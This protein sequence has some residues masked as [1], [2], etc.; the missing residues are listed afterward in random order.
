MGYFLNKKEGDMPMN[1]FVSENIAIVVIAAFAMVG[2]LIVFSA[3]AKLH[4][5]A[6]GLTI[7]SIVVP[8]IFTLCWGDGSRYVSTFAS[9]FQPAHRQQIEEA[10][11]FYKRKDAEDPFMDHDV[12]SKAITTFFETTSDQSSDSSVYIGDILSSF[13]PTA[14][15]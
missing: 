12:V 1:R 6:I 3:M 13:L 2:T 10:Y 7:L 11:N 9:F 5:I 8:V 4:R 15:P 14:D